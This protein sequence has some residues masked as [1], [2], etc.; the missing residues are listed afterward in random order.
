MTIVTN[1]NLKLVIEGI[2]KG[3][4]CK[5]K[6]TERYVSIAHFVT[7]QSMQCIQLKESYVPDGYAHSRE[8]NSRI[9]IWLPTPDSSAEEQVKYVAESR[10]LINRLVEENPNF[11]ELVLDLRC[12]IGGVLAVFIDA[13]LPI[14][15]GS[16]IINGNYM[17]GKDV[18]DKVIA[19]FTIKDGKHIINVDGE[20]IIA[21]LTEVNTPN[22][23]AGK[24]ISILCNRFTMSS[25]EILCMLFRYLG[26][27]GYFNCKIY[28]EKTRGLTN[29]CIV[30]SLGETE[31]M[32]PI[33][34]LGCGETYYKK[35]IIDVLPISAIH[36]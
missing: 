24:N 2:N 10:K 36:L 16:P 15:S 22:V 12:N 30:R 28:G 21:N 6:P 26:E 33:Y 25:G 29:G 13:I 18:N 32:I 1:S 11:T 7:L 23:F 9:F 19:T 4:F 8:N 31:V 14:I 3:S 27:L 17:Y 35:G 20:N 34:Y 5:A